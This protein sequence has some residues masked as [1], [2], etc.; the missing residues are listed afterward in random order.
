MS[1]AGTG[2]CAPTGGSSIPPGRHA[3][4]TALTANPT[5]DQVVTFLDWFG[6]PDN[7]IFDGMTLTK[8]FLPTSTATIL[9]L[10]WQLLFLFSQSRPWHFLDFSH[11]PVPRMDLRISSCSL[12]PVLVSLVP[13]LPSM[14]DSMPTQT[15]LQEDQVLRLGSLA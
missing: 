7:D 12:A 13:H 8:V 3:P 5:F 4:G 1:S 9:Q 15:K 14:L 10:P 6:H 11:L 2:G